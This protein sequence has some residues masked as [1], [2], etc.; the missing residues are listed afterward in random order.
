MELV[1]AGRC[2]QDLRWE[3]IVSSSYFFSSNT[4]ASSCFYVTPLL[5]F[6]KPIVGVLISSSLLHA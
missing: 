6:G 3:V 4:F 2:P 1:V 5:F